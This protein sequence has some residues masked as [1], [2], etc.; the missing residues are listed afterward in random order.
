MISRNVT[1]ESVL[2]FAFAF[3]CSSSEPGAAPAA[4]SNRPDS[5]EPVESGRTVLSGPALIAF[6]PLG[7]A[8]EEPSEDL[9]TALDDFSQHLSAAKPSLR[10]L[11]FHVET[12]A[13]DSTRIV[14]DTLGFAFQLPRDSADIG[15]YFA[16]PGG[17]PM[18]VYGVRTS[19]EIVQKARDFMSRKP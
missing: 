5:S 19:A 6:Y 18:I 16:A 1:I 9:S 8:G 17:P 14:Q 11:G 3:G 7:M 15:Y 12:Q 4:G 10:A 2:A 13:V